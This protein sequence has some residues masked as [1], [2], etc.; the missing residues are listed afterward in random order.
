M[1]IIVKTNCILLIKISKSLLYLKKNYNVFQK[2]M[3]T[4]LE[5]LKLIFQI[6]FIVFILVYF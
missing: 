1:K 5:L 3:F 2:L 4:S 6:I